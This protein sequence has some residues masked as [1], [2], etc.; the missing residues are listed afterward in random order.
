MERFDAPLLA[1]G[2]GGAYV[3]VPSE[4]VEALGG[5]KRI[6]VLATFDGVEYR[7]S[8]VSMGGGAMML[9][10]LKSIRT[11]LGTQPGDLLAVTVERD[12]AERTVE[13]PEDLAVA[14]EE[15]GSRPAFDALSYSHRREYVGWIEEAKRP[16]T[17]AKRVADT[18]G[19]LA[20]S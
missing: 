3:E 1:E 9:G 11:E 8:I 18:V 5:S 7:G 17:R 20:G 10:V 6:P 19:R 2:G 13:V 16:T 14:L 12:R 15:A 4:V